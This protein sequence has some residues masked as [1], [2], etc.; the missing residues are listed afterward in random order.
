MIL[1]YRIDVPVA[2]VT[3]TSLD[4]VNRTASGTALNCSTSL[5]VSLGNL[6]LPVTRSGEDWTATLP[7]EA[8]EQGSTVTATGT[9]PF[10]SDTTQATGTAP[11]YSIHAS[12][13][14]VNEGEL[15][16]FT[17]T[18][19]GVPEGT[20][21]D[22]GLSGTVTGA[23]FVTPTV[24]GAVT[25][26]ALGTATFTETA[27]TDELAEGTET[28]TVTILDPAGVR[29]ATS[30][31]VSIQEAVPPYTITADLTTVN[32]GGT[33][34]FTVTTPPVANNT[35]LYYS[36]TGTVSAADFDDTIL[37][38]SVIITGNSGTI[39]RAITA[40]NLTE[41]SKN[42]QLELRTDSVTG[43][44]VATS[45]EVTINDTSTTPATWN[46]ETP[47][48]RVLRV[49][50]QGA[51]FTGLVNGGNLN[52]A[53]V[54][55]FFETNILGEY[56]AGYFIDLILPGFITGT[57]N[58]N[59]WQY[60]HTNRTFEAAANGD[61]LVTER[62]DNHSDDYGWVGWTRG[63][64]SSSYMHWEAT[65]QDMGIHLHPIT[66]GEIE[67]LPPLKTYQLDS[68]TGIQPT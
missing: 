66:T 34:T 42:F 62:L 48:V 24:T 52:H 22:W 20:T 25:V 41:G 43:T 58:Y 5:E 28:F 19:T 2:Q 46:N 31:E 35:L 49:L 17:V 12:P 61:M 6:A 27:S 65:V 40:D 53:P 18:T 23:D 4:L 11:T 55:S 1:D 44:V 36:T 67:A 51:N 15:I 26:D 7:T 47:R 32:E 21:L 13:I 9:N 68:R 39:S 37:T 16:T 54:T 8:S 14:T 60:Y 30:E 29:V 10:N 59:Y 3:I 56:V 64:D 50:L 63:Y 38:G 57:T 45:V 33:V